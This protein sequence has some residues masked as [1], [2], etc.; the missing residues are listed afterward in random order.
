MARYKACQGFIHRKITDVDILVP[1][2]QH[3]NNGIIMINE[4]AILLWNKMQTEKTIDELCEFLG[5]KYDLD[6]ETAACD[7]QEF[8]D[9]MMSINAIEMIE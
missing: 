2:E 6:Y 8:I 5:K 3:N 7:I 4:T 1:T 9:Y